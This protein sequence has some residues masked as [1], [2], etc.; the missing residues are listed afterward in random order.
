MN[1]KKSDA[2]EEKLNNGTSS[3][4]FIQLAEA[5]R[6]QGRYE[7]AIR[8]CREGLKKTP[9][10]LRGRLILG[11]CYLERGMNTEAKQELE[12]VVAGIEECLPVFKL[13]SQVYLQEKNGDPALYHSPEEEKP[14]KGLTLL[15]MNLLQQ[16]INRQSIPV[17]A[18]IQ[19]DLA[20]PGRTLPGDQTPKVIQTDTL[21]E[22]YL[23][24]GHLEKALSIYQ[25]IL[26]R[27]P[28]NTEVQ[29][30]YEILKRRL[31]SQQKAASVQKVIH[32]LER[33]LMAVAPQGN[34][35]SP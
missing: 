6:L 2:Q 3:N 20:A 32:T 22:I 4:L 26:T 18:D 9:E 24:Q 19:E 7:E 34:S 29:G 35:P 28:G 13:L 31:G 17:E 25:E 5:H 23:K 14:K 30:K 12:K 15:E 11:K 1:D 10:A 33:W 16:K 21:A 8:I 27:E